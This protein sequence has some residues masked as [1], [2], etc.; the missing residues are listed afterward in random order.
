MRPV[1]GP[2]DEQRARAPRVA[3]TL[4]ANEHRAPRAEDERGSLL[5]GGHSRF[6]LPVSVLR[7]RSPC[8]LDAALGSTLPTPCAPPESAIFMRWTRRR[9]AGSG[10]AL[11]RRWTWMRRG[12]DAPVRPRKSALREMREMAT[13]RLRGAARLRTSPTHDSILSPAPDSPCDL[14]RLA[15]ILRSIPRTVRGAHLRTRA[16]RPG[17]VHTAAASAR[18]EVDNED[19]P[20]GAT[21]CLAPVRLERALA[22]VPA[23]V[24]VHAAE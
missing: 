20:Y 12:R 1:Y 18:L 8:A 19:I 21:V 7:Q 3:S 15:C 5:D 2:I 14:S 13:Y 16:R 4:L 17:G 24:G 9:R 22:F 11:T 23:A 6:R 10:T